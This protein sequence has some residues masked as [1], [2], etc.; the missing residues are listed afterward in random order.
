M[1]H[2]KL[3]MSLTKEELVA[4]VV[5]LQIEFQELSKQNKELKEEMELKENEA[6]RLVMSV[7]KSAEDYLKHQGG[8]K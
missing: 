5:K 3:L 1:L 6:F 2:E 8:S 7:L 4:M